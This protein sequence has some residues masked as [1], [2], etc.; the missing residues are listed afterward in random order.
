MRYKSG[1]SVSQQR[2]AT[3]SNLHNSR[4][5]AP[6]TKSAASSESDT[7]KGLTPAQCS[8]NV[9]IMPVTKVVTVT[10]SVTPRLLRIKDAAVYL[11]VSPWKVRELIRDGKLRLALDPDDD[12]E[13]TPWRVPLED[14]D[15]HIDS[16]LQKRDCA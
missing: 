3:A 7:S 11:A 15:A 10:E 8:N 4:F 12:P 9:R 6:D 13:K 16:I 14:L 5:T 2:A 1:R